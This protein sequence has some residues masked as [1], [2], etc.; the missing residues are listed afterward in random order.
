MSAPLRIGLLG[1]AR[2][3]ELALISPAHATGHRLV[4]VAARDPQRARAFAES[5]GIERV[6]DDYWQLI[7]DPDV[8]VVYNPLANGLHAP[9]NLRAIQA[10]KQVL[11]E[12]P[13]ASNAVEARQIRDA[14]T[15]AGVLCG[16]AFHYM[17]HPLMQRILELAA[18]GEI[19]E[20]EL[21][22]ARMLMP[23]PPADDPRWKAEL[24]GGSL[25]DVGCY[26]VHAARDFAGLLGGEPLVAWARGGEIPDHPGVDAWIEAELVYPSG[27]PALVS[28]S[29]THGSWDFSL[30]VVG[31][32]GELFAPAFVRPHID[33]Q[34]VITTG[35]RQRTE[36]LGKR[37]S[38]TYQL[39]AFARSVLEGEP[40]LTDADDAAVNMATIDAIY[41][42]ASREPH[43]IVDLED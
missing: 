28:S 6:V 15:Q 12:K 34:L 32:K 23:P 16:E 27:V 41:T 36:E 11:S 1:A 22:D 26:A 37:S 21:V 10:G 17:Y 20:V 5:H 8:D 7:N 40:F 14:A 38:Y 4:A 42:A 3:S 29:M 2:I 9:W 18:D 33:D 13:Y 35:T 24:A 43:R 19:G 39:E 30:R 25:M 31:S